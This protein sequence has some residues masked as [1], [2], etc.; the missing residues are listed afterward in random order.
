MSYLLKTESEARISRVRNILSARNLDLAF[1]YYDEFNIG[2]GWYLTGW[3]PQFESGAVLVPREGEPLILGGP[4][5][6]PFARLDSAIKETRNFPVFMVPDEEYPNAEIID[7][8]ILFKEL[9]QTL[10]S[11]KRI[12]LV[13]ADRMPMGCYRQIEEGFSGVELVDITGE[14]VSLRFIKSG[15]EREQIRNAFRL[16]D[17][18]YQAMMEVIKPG[19]SEI[20]VAAAGEY[21]VRSR[22]ANGFGFGTIIGS[23][24]RSN[25]VVPT[26]GIKVLQE[27]ELVMVGI[28]P[29]VSGYTG[30]VG[31]TLP[32]SGQYTE[33]QQV[34]IN[35]LKSAFQLAKAQLI[36]G[37][38][39]R[40]IDAPV[41]AYFEKHGFSGYLVCPFVH[42]IGLHEAESPFFGPHSDDMLKEG[43]MVCIDISFFGHPEYNGVRIETGY[44]IGPSGPIAL[45][46][47]MDALYTGEVLQ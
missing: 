25:A 44:E 43:M 41:R 6:E 12:G 18:A 29:K 28:S 33:S 16:A 26:A 30:V 37:K 20:Q 21:A 13:G 38:A 9:N 46:P 19:V 4:E 45:S 32:V 42:T 39:G 11:I 22:G 5:S 27:G 7:F 40:E 24:A 1:V 2:N 34:C 10:G 8:S 17:H 36:P 3:C 31:D 35:H 14:Y 23:G 15:W 47:L